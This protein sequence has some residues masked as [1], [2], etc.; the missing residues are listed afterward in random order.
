MIADARMPG[1]CEQRSRQQG[2]RSYFVDIA[3]AARK[4]ISNAA[5]AFDTLDYWTWAMITPAGFIIYSAQF[6][7]Q[8]HAVTT[9][10]L[11][12]AAYYYIRLDDGRVTPCRFTYVR[13]DDL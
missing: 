6:R 2:R 12:I 11:Y 10:I 1:Q 4:E 13:V 5:A 9:T 8:V 7:R 3:G